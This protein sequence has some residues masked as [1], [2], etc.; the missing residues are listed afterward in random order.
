MLFSQFLQGHSNDSRGATRTKGLLLTGRHPLW[1][2]RA[3]P[4][5][6]VHGWQSAAPTLR[7]HSDRNNRDAYPRSRRSKETSQE[8]RSIWVATSARIPEAPLGTEHHPPPEAPSTPHEDGDGG[9]QAA[10]DGPLSTFQQ[11]LAA[12]RRCGL[13]R[14]N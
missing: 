13:R 4:G 12:V 14:R 2:G 1:G 9:A 5:G 8:L 6:S 7:P 10:Q 11:R 3:G